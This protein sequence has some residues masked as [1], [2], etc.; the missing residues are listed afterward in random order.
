MLGDKNRPLTTMGVDRDDLRF[1]MLMALLANINRDP[2]KGKPFG[3]YDFMLTL[4]Q[5]EGPAQRDPA[6]GAPAPTPEVLLAKVVMLNA[7][8]GGKDLR[9]VPDKRT[10]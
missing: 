3:P 5:A 8:F 7:A 4:T 1:A 10:Q 6:R 2:K 9:A